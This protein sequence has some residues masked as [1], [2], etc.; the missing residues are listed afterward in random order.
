M[1]GWTVLFSATSLC[2]ALAL[3][4]SPSSAP[5]TAKA[6][7]EVSGTLRI[8]GHG[9][10]DKDY[11]GS[12][13]TAWENGFRKRYPDVRFET[14][15]KGDKS[16]IGA[17][18]TG[19][20]D[21]AIMEREL[22][23]I[24]KDGYEQI[25]GRTDPFEVSVATGSLDRR[26]HA[27]AL[28]VFV[29]RDNPLEKLTLA[30]LDAIFGADHWRGLDNIRT[31]GALGLAGEWVAKPINA[32]G[33]EIVEDPSQYFQKAVMGGSQKW[34]GNLKEFG[35]L[36]EA[37]GSVTEA[38]QR[39]VDALAHDRY[40]IAISHMAYR[41]PQVKP[42]ALAVNEG[43]AYYEPTRET[44]QSREYPL[45]RTVSVYANRAPQQPLDPKVREFL[46]YVL[47]SEGQ[48]DV[49]R[50]AGYF[51]LTAEV[52]AAERRKTE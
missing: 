22:S 44:V 15:L 39:I 45:T 49:S 8:W 33:F 20:A 26:N 6:A 34:A 29:H 32:Y 10:R 38:G 47:G 5:V 16:A 24:E 46:R 36:R 12:L 35:N 17:L 7:E 18:Y 3:A 31:W 21:L 40:G 43:G 11:V 9:S 42:L 37:D 13:V 4:Q 27:M 41:T 2:G 25:F 23:A 14:S 30:Q 50:D 51:P 19:A 1:R 52:A 48:D 28:V